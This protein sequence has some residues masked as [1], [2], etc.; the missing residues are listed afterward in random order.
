MPSYPTIPQQYNLLPKFLRRPYDGITGREGMS[1]RKEETK[2]ELSW[3][4][5]A[6]DGRRHDH[7][8]YSESYFASFPPGAFVADIGC[9]DGWALQVLL[10][11]GCRGV[12]TEVDDGSLTKAR[13]A[14]RPVLKAVAEALPLLTGTVD[15]VVFN[16]VLPF[17][18]EDEAFAEM[19][20]VLRPG[21]RLEANYLGA[22]FALR[23]LLLGVNLRNR[24]FG[25]RALINTILMHL[26]RRKLPGRFGDTV[27]VSH[28]RLARLYA[29]HGFTLRRHTPSP[30]FLGL[31]VFIYHSAERTSASGQPLSS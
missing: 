3:A 29:R 17:T 31:P 15:G 30:T 7:Y 27:Y 26:V 9:G 24:A 10:A 11:R 4:A 25:L 23:D 21:G 13:A 6:L 12:G 19:A 28:Q 8:Y 18:E 14:G 2:K 20:R 1:D 16:G 5:Y 22:G